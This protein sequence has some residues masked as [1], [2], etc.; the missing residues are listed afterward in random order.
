MSFSLTHHKEGSQP[1]VFTATGGTR[2]FIVRAGPGNRADLEYLNGFVSGVSDRNTDTP[3]VANGVEQ[4][5]KVSN[6]LREMIAAS[7]SKFLEDANVSY[8][9][10]P[11]RFYH[12]GEA[13]SLFTF[14]HVMARFRGVSEDGMMNRPQSL[15]ILE[16]IETDAFRN[17]DSSVLETIVL[18][19]GFDTMQRLFTKAGIHAENC[20]WGPVA[21][22][23]SIID[24][25]VD[26]DQKCMVHSLMDGSM[27]LA[28]PGVWAN[29]VGVPKSKTKP[30]SNS[31][32]N[33]ISSKR[34][35]LK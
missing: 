13:K 22:S 3:S 27:S 14:S 18:I 15:S 10:R 12:D 20:Y 11:T 35:K 5:N 31:K 9:T 23:V 25:P 33:S 28:L 19:V 34:Q 4:A 30:R 2:A 17:R 29:A 7:G 8:N 21:G 16:W 24:Y 1:L 6:G 26:D 32:P